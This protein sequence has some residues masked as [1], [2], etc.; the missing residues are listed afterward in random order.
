MKRG[1][2]TSPR[3]SALSQPLRITT[4][5]RFDLMRE[6]IER[7]EV[8]KREKPIK[9]QCLVCGYIFEREK[10]AEEMPGLLTSYQHFMPIEDTCKC[11]VNKMSIRVVNSLIVEFIS[12]YVLWCRGCMPPVFVGCRAGARGALQDIKTC[13][14]SQSDR[15]KTLILIIL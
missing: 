14:F 9:W 1:S 11:Y 3:C 7:G 12:E 5:E 10:A 13:R 15:L 6:R 8:W 4:K 2:P